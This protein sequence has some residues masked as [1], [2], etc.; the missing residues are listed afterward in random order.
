MPSIHEYLELLEYLKNFK[1]YVL[2][3]EKEDLIKKMVAIELL[4]EEDIVERENLSTMDIYKKCNQR[5]INH[6]HKKKRTQNLIIND[7]LIV[8]KYTTHYLT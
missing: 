2:M 4:K 1:K 7:T 3:L 5:I 6:I 8:V